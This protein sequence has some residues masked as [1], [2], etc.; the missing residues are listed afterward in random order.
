MSSIANNSKETIRNRMQRHA[1]NYWNIR[2]TEDLDPMVKLILEALSTEL[3]NLGND[4]KD[5]EVRLLEKI[6]NLLA[7]DFLT[8]PNAAHSILRAIPVEAQEVIPETTHFYTQKK[9]SS[10]QDETLDKTVDVFFT[11]VDRVRL[12]HADVACMITGNQVTAF[13]ESGNKQ[14]LG[15]TIIGRKLDGHELWLGVSLSEKISSLEKLSFYFDWK[16]TPYEVASFNYQLLSLSKWYINDKELETRE[17]LAYVSETEL[18]QKNKHQAVDHDLLELMER[19]IKAYYQ[20]KFVTITDQISNPATSQGDTV[21][22][23]IH[24][25]VQEADLKTLKQN[26][27]WIR[28]VFPAA[29]QM[30]S[31]EEAYVYTNCF[32]VMNRQLNDLRYR[33]KSGSNIIPLKTNGLYQFLSVRSLADESH[34]FRPTP[35]RNMEEEETGTFTLRRGGAERFDE[36]NAKEFISYLLEL[37]RSESA[38]FSAYGNDFIASTLREMDQRIALMEQKTKSLA[39]STAEIPHYIIAKPYD[40]NEMVF[41]EYWT[42]L[43]ETA[44]AIRAGS[45]LQEYQGVRFRSDSMILLHT[46]TGGKSRLKPEERVNAFRYGLMTRNRIVTKEDIRNLCSYELGSRVSKVTVEKGFEMSA[47][48]RQGFLRTIDIRLTAS[49]SEKL[50]AEGWQVLLDQLK[51]KLQERSGMTNHY[52][53]MLQK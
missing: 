17:G 23:A 4:L 10:R 27:V 36:R 1:M 31:L 15:P 3:Y 46:T 44:N 49:A 45:R 42:T 30:N 32:P 41:V 7:P 34:Q 11:P 8:C 33:L 19:D 25:L 24:E 43:A 22:A 21:P 50:S 14:P 18:S 35:F 20:Q 53:V 12:H 13:D 9:Y 26:L 48:P 28:I 37:L 52:R 40:K 51:A 47:D 5:T 29:M 2:N 39:N 16:N 38:A 6:A